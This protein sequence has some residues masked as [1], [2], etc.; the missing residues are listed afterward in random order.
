MNTFEHQRIARE[1]RELVAGPDPFAAAMRASPLPMVITDPRKDDNPIV[2]VNDAFLALTGYSREE[3]LGKNCR[4][5]QGPG[6]N[7]DD[8][9]RLREAVAARKTIELELLNYRRDGSIFW[10]RLTV[11]PVFDGDEL[12]FFF[13]S[14]HER[15][16]RAIKDQEDYQQDLQRRIADLIASEER[17]HFTLKA[18]SL[19]TWTLDIPSQR[20]SC[21]AL[22][23][24]N[25]GRNPTDTFGYD[26][27]KAAVH[28]GDRERW[29]GAVMEAL[30]SDGHLQVE[31]RI[32]RPDGTVSWIE[33]RA[34]TKFDAEGRPLA[35]NGI[36]LDIT[37][38]KEIE[39]QRAVVS[40]EMGHRIKN[41]MATVQSIVNQSMRGD[42]DVVSMR[43]NITSRLDALGRSHDVLR[44]RDFA[45]A[46]ITAVIDRAIEPFN[47]NDRFLIQGPDFLLSHQG[48]NTLALSVHELATNAVK[49]GALSNKDGQVRVVWTIDG[50]D[51]YFTW[52]EQG[53]PPVSPPGKAG[54]GTRLIR[55][56]GL[57]LSGSASL[58]YHPDGVVFTA[59]TSLS[60]LSSPKL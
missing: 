34:E 11:S 4:F 17:L 35:L 32:N 45:S 46:N 14:Q 18:G 7:A 15:A 50:D 27:L 33:V 22:C 41:M 54:F 37:E 44:G 42:L 40:Q 49:Y 25:F 31:Y 39:A 48:A 2:F 58:D 51:F 13:A 53:G 52:T 20:L 38:R 24:M 56:L 36:S 26:E 28:P 1:I 59:S 55:M 9:R 23:K 30:S 8:V 3:A 6:T 21:S 29:Q 12:T 57:G 47:T 43:K 19:G 16:I 60:S 5:L 10:N